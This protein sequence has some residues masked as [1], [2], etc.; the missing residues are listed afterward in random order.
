[1]NDL[2]QQ[3]AN[4]DTVRL[5]AALVLLDIVLGIAAAVKAGIFQLNYLVDFL[6]NDI[7]GKAV[8]Y[9]AVWAAVRLGGDLEIGGYGAIEEVVGAGV[10]LALGASVLNSLSELGLGK[11]LPA[12]IAGDDPSAKI[13]APKS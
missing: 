12:V 4:D 8:P 11:S 3:F 6:R 9:F 2:I 5:I 10:V 13:E 1:M 7:L